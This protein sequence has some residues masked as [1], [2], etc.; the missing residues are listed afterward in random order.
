MCRLPFICVL[1][2]FCFQ[3]SFAKDLLVSGKH[4]Q[5][6]L[7]ELSEAQN[8]IF[9]WGF[10]RSGKKKKKP[11]RKEITSCGLC[12]RRTVLWV[13]FKPNPPPP[14][15]PLCYC[16]PII[17]ANLRL[18]RAL[19]STLMNTDELVCALVCTEI[20]SLVNFKNGQCLCTWLWKKEGSKGP[21]LSYIL[22]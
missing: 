22:Q 9:K 3:S 20:T 21:I 2:L 15:R 12:A 5:F 13:K 17:A 10:L 19:H 4:L 1:S 16:L 8:G 7:R 11:G 14:G 18:N 6:S